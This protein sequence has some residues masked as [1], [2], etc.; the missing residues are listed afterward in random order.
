MSRKKILMVDDAVT[1]LMMEKMFLSKEPYDL[2][3][4]KNGQE[5]HTCCVLFSAVSYLYLQRF[6]MAEP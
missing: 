4:A 2:I 6:Q 1:I 5:D 3:T